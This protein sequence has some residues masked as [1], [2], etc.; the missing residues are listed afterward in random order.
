[1]HLQSLHGEHSAFKSAPW[2]KGKVQAWQ[3][4]TGVPT[5]TLITTPPPNNIGAPH[6]FQVSNQ[7]SRRAWETKTRRL[8]FSSLNLYNSTLPLPHSNDPSPHS[9]SSLH[10]SSLYN[11]LCVLPTAH[12][13]HL[14]HPSPNHPMTKEQ[15]KNL[16]KWLEV[17][18]GSIHFLTGFPSLPDL[19]LFKSTADNVFLLYPPS[20]SP[21]PLSLFLSTEETLLKADTRSSE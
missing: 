2:L 3:R 15:K 19:S 8:Y 11:L 6:P 17:V 16:R 20:P 7:H 1:M 13:S 5:A 4:T 9:S 14:P 12:L 10:F 21:P 18:G